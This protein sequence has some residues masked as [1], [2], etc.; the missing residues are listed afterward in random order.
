MGLM[1][2]YLLFLDSYGLVFGA[3]TLTRGLVCL[4]YMLLALTSSVSLGSE[5]LGTRDRILSSVLRLPLS[6]PPTTHRVT[7][8]VFDPASTGV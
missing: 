2:R 4:L 6:S 8:E 7:V 3:P 1:T 5:S